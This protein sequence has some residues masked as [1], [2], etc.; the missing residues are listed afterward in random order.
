M[1]KLI[2]RLSRE[3]ANFTTILEVSMY[4]K[5]GINYSLPDDVYAERSSQW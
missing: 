2:P 3:N 1:E 5:K 4:D